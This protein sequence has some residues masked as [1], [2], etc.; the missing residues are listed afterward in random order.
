MNY[1]NWNKR[2]I[3]FFREELHLV[4]NEE[5]SKFPSIVNFKQRGKYN[6]ELRKKLIDYFS[7]SVALLSTSYKHLNAYTLEEVSSLNYFTDG[8]FIFTDLLCKYIY[9]DDFVLPEKWLAVIELKNF[10]HE[11]FVLDYERMASGEIDVFD[12]LDQ[13][14]ESSNL[15]RSFILYTNHD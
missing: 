9:Y 7:N 1:S 5:L 14:I 4:R 12:C 2:G 6:S 11:Q 15:I 10:I 8:D 3:S 13:S